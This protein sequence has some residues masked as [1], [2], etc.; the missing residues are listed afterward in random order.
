MSE[1]KEYTPGTFCWVELSTTDQNGAKQ[2]Y[3]QLLGLDVRDIPFGEGS[4]YTILTQRGLEAGAI[5]TQDPAQAQ[6]G[7]PPHWL[8]Y[9][10]VASVD[11]SAK[12]AGELGG[13]VVAGPFDVMDAGRMAV[14]MDPT[15]AAFA[16]WQAGNSI[17]A[18]IVNEPGSWCWNE[19]GTNDTDV[20]GK[21]YSDLFGWGLN[22]LDMGGMTYTLLKHGEK[23]AGGMYKI[24][25][26]MGGMPPNW[27]VYF[28][29]ADCDQSAEKATSLGGKVIMP[30]S[31]IP[32]VGRFSLVQ[33]P[34]GAFFGIIKLNHPA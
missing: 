28:S 15:G 2:F 22:A 7:I 34:Q 1:L 21:F 20:D 13:Q 33:D 24:T 5:C 16:L 4:V 23:D 8:S 32:N 31:D 26:E 25:P 29:V 30:P 19:L 9:V 6:Q 18:R 14:V 11:E 12:K 17:G 27:L 10:S 3:T